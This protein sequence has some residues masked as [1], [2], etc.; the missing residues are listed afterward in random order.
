MFI[1]GLMWPYGQGHMA[2]GGHRRGTPELDIASYLILMRNKTVTVN[3][4]HDALI[5]LQDGYS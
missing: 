5:L 3:F 2:T 4:A 1:E